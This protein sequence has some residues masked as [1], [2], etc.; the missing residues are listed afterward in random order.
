MDKNGIVIYLF[1]YDDSARIWNTGDRAG[2]EEKDFIH[3]LVNRFELYNNLIWCIAEEY[4]EVFSVER[5]RNIAGEIRAAD[6]Y[7]HV[8]AVHKLN[9]LDFS[10]FGDEPNIDQFAIQ[11]N[12]SNADALH[13]GMVSAWKGAQGRYNLNM[14]EAAD[15]GSGQEARKKSWACAMG[16]AYVMILRMDIA[17]TSKD[18]LEDCG[19]LVRFFE[20][21]NFNE[22]SP[23]DELRY[24]G[25]QY[26]LAQPGSSYIAYAPE[27]R[28]K[29]GLKDMRGGSYEF[30]WL[31]CVNGK[32]VTQ[33]RVR[34]GAGNQ[35]WKK[36]GG[37]GSELA[38]YIRRTG[39]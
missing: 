37:I 9:G 8:I 6:D 7:D 10:E 1:L 24:R 39:K 5:V 19:W 3:T 36:P 25:T 16:G 4:Q 20:S 22:M 38:V 33:T 14:S 30:R 29:I 17:G 13:K 26:V 31:D 11:Y 15:Y 34:I 28:G 32:E 2:E 21:T 18:D 27:L 23:H 12:V 35:S